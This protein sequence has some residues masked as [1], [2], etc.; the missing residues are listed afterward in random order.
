MDMVDSTL[1]RTIASV[2]IVIEHCRG[3]GATIV[4][5]TFS[6]TV[7]DATFRQSRRW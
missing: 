2:L 4:R 1:L 3:R 7:R 6:V 5:A